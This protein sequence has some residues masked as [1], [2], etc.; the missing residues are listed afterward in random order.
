LIWDKLN[1]RDKAALLKDLYPYFLPKMKSV[2]LD[3]NIKKLSEQQVNE[4]VEQLFKTK[5]NVEESKGTR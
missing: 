4:L 1:F 3:L 5:D 2:V